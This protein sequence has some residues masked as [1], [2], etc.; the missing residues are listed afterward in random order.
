MNFTITQKMKIEFSFD[1]AH[2]ASFIEI[3]AILRKSN[4]ENLNK[5]WWYQNIFREKI[6]DVNSPGQK[7]PLPKKL[8]F[9][10]Q[11]MRNVLKRMKKLFFDFFFQF[12]DS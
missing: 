3:G 7:P 2:C 1:S 9:W 10:S 6:L 4:L 11:T 8:R 5:K 12:N